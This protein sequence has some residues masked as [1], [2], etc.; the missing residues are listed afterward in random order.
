MEELKWITPF[1]PKRRWKCERHNV[2]IS[3]EKCPL[4]EYENYYI[5]VIAKIPGNL[6]R[7]KA[8]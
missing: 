2:E 1:L 7:K 4:C 6:R 3:G 5:R 8:H